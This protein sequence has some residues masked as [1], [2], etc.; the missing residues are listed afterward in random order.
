MKRSIINPSILLFSKTPAFSAIF[1]GLL[2]LL[3][4]CT[5][6]TSD[7]N[8]SPGEYPG[9]K[10]E[11]YSPEIYIDNSNYRNLAYN[12]PAYHSSSY[13]Y[14]LTAQ[15]VTD[16]IKDTVVPYWI[17]TSTSEHG[18]LKKREREWL[19]DHNWMTSLYLDT[20]SIWLQFEMGGGKNIPEIDSIVLSARLS[21]DGQKPG[22]W[23]FTVLGSN[24]GQ[25]W[26]SLGHI[27]GNDY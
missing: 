22:G 8:R 7:F 2:I 25:K 1:I 26:E 11:D 21:H 20:S 6:K 9:N 19:F 23:D 16:G 3:T 10:N 15:L 12:R 5:V 27:W 17:S 18:I 14:N 24:D 13:D 4:M